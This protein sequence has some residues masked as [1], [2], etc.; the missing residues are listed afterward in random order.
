MSVGRGYFIEDHYSIDD[1][2][3]IIKDSTLEN[4]ILTRAIFI[5][6]LLQGSTIKE[7]SDKVGVAR[8]TGSRWLK[9]YNEK[10]LSGLIPK[11]AS[12]RPGKLTNQQKKELKNILIDKNSNYTIME[13]VELIKEKY[14]VDLS[15]K[16]VWTIIRVE[17][18]LNYNKPFSNANEKPKN[19][20]ELLKKIK[21]S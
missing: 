17:F 20:R 9:R 3:R 1:L 5:R 11:L 13:V 19:Q 21:K 8:Q 12:G 14:D 18:N 2:K 6:M 15:Y 7:A 10:G 16:R 4:K